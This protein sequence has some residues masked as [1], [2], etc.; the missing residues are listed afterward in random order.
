MDKI[1]KFL[2]KLSQK[3]RE[4]IKEILEQLHRKNWS[5]L[6]IKKLKEREDIFRVRKG[7]FRIIYRMTKNNI[8]ILAIERRKEKTYKL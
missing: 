7:N 3:E 8:F 5:G 4:Q 2:R 6:D 1:E